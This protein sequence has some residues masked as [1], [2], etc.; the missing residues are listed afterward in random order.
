MRTGVLMFAALAFV[1]GG[2][3]YSSV[4][5]TKQI[6]RME[7]MDTKD[8]KD[9]VNAEGKGK[10]DAEGKAK[11]DIPKE[12][13]DMLIQKG[14]KLYLYNTRQEE[15]EGVN[16]IVFNNLDEYT[17]YRNGDPNQEQCPILFLKQENNAQ[18]QDVYRRIIPGNGAQ[19]LGQPIKVVDA[20]RENGFNQNMYAGFDPYGMHV[21]QFTELDARHLST[22]KGPGPSDNPMDPNWGGVL[23]TQAA[24]QSGKY[25]ENNVY[26][27]NYATPKGGQ[28]IPV[29]GGPPPPGNKSIPSISERTGRVMGGP[30]M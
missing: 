6:E 16:P 19:G 25:D 5:I 12:C 10:V 1:A 7:G 3:V 27:T 2:I 8:N 21:G 4:D 14:T 24:V 20:S 15:K 13:P 23:H 29:P 22:E 9:S 11:D 30:S 18:G 17:N 28:F 26:P